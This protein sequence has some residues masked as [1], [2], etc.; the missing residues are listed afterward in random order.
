[1]KVSTSL[2]LPPNSPLVVV[3]TRRLGEIMK[4]L[5]PMENLLERSKMTNSL[6]LITRNTDR[7]QLLSFSLVPTGLCIYFG[8]LLLF[9]VSAPVIIIFQ[10]L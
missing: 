6:R 10:L 8:L 3:V 2:L 9:A 7:H 4:V 1:M 5:Y